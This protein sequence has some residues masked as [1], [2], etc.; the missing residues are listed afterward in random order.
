MSIEALGRNVPKQVERAAPAPLAGARD[1]RL[2]QPPVPQMPMYLPPQTPM[3]MQM[4]MYVP[5]Q[6]MDMPQPVPQPMYAPPPAPPAPPAPAAPAER[7]IGSGWR[8]RPRGGAHG[9][10]TG[11]GFGNSRWGAIGKGGPSRPPP[12]TY[13]CNRC[14]V[15]GHWIHDCPTLKKGKR[16]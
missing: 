6:P 5:P 15:G 8:E 16:R 11:G 3:Q 4:Q 9:S 1:P 14:K 13:I 10:R 7:A 12:A 2:A